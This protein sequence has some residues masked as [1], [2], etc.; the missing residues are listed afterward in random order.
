L[1]DPIRRTAVS[2]LG[3]TETVAPH[4]GQGNSIGFGGSSGMS[5]SAQAGALKYVGTSEA[6]QDG[7]PLDGLPV[8]AA[9]LVKRKLPAKNRVPPLQLV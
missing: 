5:A 4:V 3:W 2:S 1:S 7:E 8:S 9:G 6:R